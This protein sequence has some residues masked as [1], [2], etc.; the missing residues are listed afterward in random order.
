MLK[1]VLLI[2]AHQL[3]AH[4]QYNQRRIKLSC[5]IARNALNY[6]KTVQQLI[7]RADIVDAWHLATEVQ[8]G[9]LLLRTCMYIQMFHKMLFTGHT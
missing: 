7:L 5:L 3:S 1:K 8:T 2:V 9:F 4:V 6:Q